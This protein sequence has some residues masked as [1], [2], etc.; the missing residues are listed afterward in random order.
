MTRVG[1]NADA[2]T[3]YK[4]ALRINPNY[5]EAKRALAELEKH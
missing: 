4:E 3:H 5:A 1:R 2:I